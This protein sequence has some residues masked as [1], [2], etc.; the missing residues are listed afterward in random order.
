MCLSLLELLHPDG[1]TH[2]AYV[3]GGNCPERLRPSQPRMS[4]T[5]ADLVILAPTPGECRR[6][7]WLTNAIRD[8][9][10][11][12]A[13]D[14]FVY[15]LAPPRWR[16]TI[17]RLLTRSGLIL[18]PPAVH[19]P[20]W[21][22]SRYL[23]PLTTVPA[24]YALANLLPNPAWKRRLAQ[25]G[26][27]FRGI[28]TIAGWAWPAAAFAARR[29]GSRPL[30]DWL[31][32]LD[33]DGRAQGGVVITASWR[34]DQQSVVLHRFSGH[35][36]PSAIAKLVTPM[37]MEAAILARLS[38]VAAAAG[39][40]VPA[41]LTSGSVGEHPVFL[42]SVVAGQSVATL[43]RARPT[44]LAEVLARVSTWLEA[45][46][47]ATRLERRQVGQDLDRLIMRPAARLAPLLAEG[48]TYLS[49]LARR[50]AQ[51]DRALPLV[52]AHND[53]TTWNVLIDETGR[54]GVVDWETAH[55]EALPLVDFFYLVAD[56][57]VMAHGGQA[58]LERH[59]AVEAFLAPYG[60]CAPIARPLLARLRDALDLPLQA[61]DLCL[62]AAF[63]G[64]AVNERRRSQPGDPQPFAD[65]VRWLVSHREQVF[66]WTSR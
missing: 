16:A 22:T 46:N 31:F 58:Q 14:G 8:V 32:R 17:G 51:I 41:L 55:E 5:S 18:E 23:V 57:V 29:R 50:C 28:Q 30:L 6:T 37:P 63:I 53:L 7:G 39:A 36:D 49:W 44:R 25:L 60:A 13:A 12:L 9:E 21:S 43:L 15:V 65:V 34:P 59:R 52:V 24:G 48:H 19:L 61:V 66:D 42:Q 11:R 54:L 62:H 27:R 35:A 40:Q 1:V 38:P 2:Y 33:C 3:I 47:V 26:L 45:W 64:H 20:N 4:G 56:A 10:P